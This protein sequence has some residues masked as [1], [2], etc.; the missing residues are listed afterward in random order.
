MS[1][2]NGAQDP[3]APA[4]FKVASSGN[5]VKGSAMELFAPDPNAA[6]ESVSL[7]IYYYVTPC[8]ALINSS[9]DEVSLSILRSLVHINDTTAL[10][11]NSIKSIFSS[12][13]TGAT[14]P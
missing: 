14:R 4:M 10:S 11:H 1:T 5:V 2:S 6:G 12:L 3:A 7:V 8:F 13:Q 9:H